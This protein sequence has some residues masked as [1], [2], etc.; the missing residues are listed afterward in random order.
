MKNNK[1][2]VLGVAA[3]TF[4]LVLAGCDNGTTGGG[5]VAVTGISGVQTA[6]IVGRPLSL[7]GTVEPSGASNKT[8]VWSGSGVSDGKL[9]AASAGSYTVTATIEKGESESAPF[10]RNFT[11]TAYDAS[12]S[13]SNPFGAATPFIWAM[14]YTGGT[15]YVSIKDTTWEAFVDGSSYS[16]GTYTRFD[17]TAAGQWTVGAGGYAGD[18]GLMIMIDTDQFLVANFA[19]DYS[20][21]NGTFTKLNTSLTA[22]GTWQTS[23]QYDGMYAKIVAASDGTWTEYLSADKSTWIEVVKGTFP[24]TGATNP[25][26]CTI[27]DGNST[28]DKGTTTWTAWNSLSQELKN[29]FGGSQTFTVL[30]Y[31]D[32]IETFGMTFEKQGG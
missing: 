1:L 9:T 4:G 22:E 31:S 23:D 19:N 8:I 7:S 25:A 12:T 29:T 24:Q 26:V 20:H 32:K 2:F 17:G 10:T 5:F 3:L 28:Y 6:A 27:T 21:M 16:T 11:I 18:T 13:V 14:D 30:I 15:V